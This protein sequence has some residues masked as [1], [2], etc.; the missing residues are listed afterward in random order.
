MDHTIENLQYG[1]QFNTAS[2]GQ[3]R[4]HSRGHPSTEV[5]AASHSHDILCG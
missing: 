2:A 4:P 3:R 1:L 5:Y